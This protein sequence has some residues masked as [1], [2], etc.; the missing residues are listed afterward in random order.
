LADGFGNPYDHVELDEWAIIP[1]HPHGIRKGWAILPLIRDNGKVNILIITGLSGA[2]KSTALHAFEDAGYYG[3]DNLP[4]FLLVQLARG[5]AKKESRLALVMDVRDEDFL[6]YFPQA[7]A[8]CR[9]ENFKIEILFLEAE[10][11]TLIRRF[12]QLRRVHPLSPRGAVREG[13]ILEKQRLTTLRA[14]ADQVIDSSGMTPQELR[15]LLVER[16]TQGSGSGGLQVNLISFGHKHGL[17]TEADLVFD[18]R[19]LPNPH[20]VPE[21]KVLT[22]RNGEVSSYALKNLTGKKFIELLLSLLNFLIPLYQKEGKAYLNI[23]VGC[24]GGKHRSVAVAELLR[25]SLEQ[26]QV[27]ISVLHRDIGKEE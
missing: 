6:R 7:V 12:S 5:M 26:K 15:Q 24:T 27:N 18:V 25:K 1:N 13:I 2:G 9:A 22:G 4:V 3:I 23:A 14:L 21:L 17:P 11:N 16:Y 8:G 10:E 19:F 20:Y